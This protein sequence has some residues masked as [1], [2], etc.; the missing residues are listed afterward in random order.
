LENGTSG[1]LLA[2]PSAHLLSARF[3]TVPEAKLAIKQA[4]LKKRQI[5]QEKKAV[6]D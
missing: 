3:A 1:P 4:R 5:A 2:S 6:K